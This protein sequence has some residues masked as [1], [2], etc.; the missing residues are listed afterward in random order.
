M[1]SAV[2]VVTEGEEDVVRVDLHD[3]SNEILEFLFGAPIGMVAET[4]NEVEVAF[5]YR[6]RKTMCIRDYKHPCWADIL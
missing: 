1:I 6:P 4:D 2:L 5:G 3:L